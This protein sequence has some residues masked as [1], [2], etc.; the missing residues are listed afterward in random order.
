MK[1]I[2]KTLFVGF[3]ILH[4]FLSYSQDKEAVAGGL[5]PEQRSLLQNQ[6]ELMI[7]NRE[8]FKTSLTPE[9]RNILESKDLSPKDQQAAL[10]ASL[11]E[12]QR[13]LI[14]ENLSKAKQIKENFAGT[15]TEEQRQ[16]IRKLNENRNSE[17]V[18]EM[19]RKFL[20]NRLTR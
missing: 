14:F 4:S 8:K 18:R 3:I 10:M 2:I 13:A 9:Q 7:Q 11:N 5:T 16:R 12:T 19:R 15:L 1:K 6:R 17:S 20:L